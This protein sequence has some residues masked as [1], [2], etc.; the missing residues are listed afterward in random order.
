MKLSKRQQEVVDLLSDG[1]E[2]GF[3]NT[4]NGSVWIQKGGVG[5]GGETRN[6]HTATVFALLDRGIIMCV[7]S[8]FPTSCYRLT[9]AAV[10]P[11]A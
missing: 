1:W 8:G 9:T 7:R 4:F 5:R 11:P 6:V 2:I 10:K 3:S